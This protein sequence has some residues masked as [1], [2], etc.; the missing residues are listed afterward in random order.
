M[1]QAG[2]QVNWSTGGC[3]AD[4]SAPTSPT[5]G[6]EA[7]RRRRPRS[8]ADAAEL[9]VAAPAG[10]M[11]AWLV[12][13][14]RGG[15]AVAR[16]G[17]PGGGEQHRP[18][19]AARRAGRPR[20]NKAARSPSAD[21]TDYCRAGEMAGV[22]LATST[23]AFGA[24]RKRR[25][26]RREAVGREHAKPSQQRRGRRAAAARGWRGGAAVE[27]SAQPAGGPARHGLRA[28]PATVPAPAGERIW[29]AHPGGAH[30]SGFARHFGP[31][32]R[33]FRP[34][35]S[36]NPFP[37]PRD[38]RKC[39]RQEPPRSK[40]PQEPRPARRNRPPPTSLHRLGGSFAR[41]SRSDAPVGDS[42][43]E[44]RARRLP[45]GGFARTNRF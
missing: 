11:A 41:G 18:D 45:L 19:A 20:W 9:A 23:A 42:L 26:E 21:G 35:D 22:V 3:S 31:A 32:W 28:S 1:M 36:L 37:L 27:G 2:P 16:G 34:Q 24:A 39:G 29:R 12:T 7:Q 8:A 33:Y 14:T 15:C 30:L 13:C 6:F 43:L 38:Q 10:A 44:A 17:G 25:S 5:S 4:A 40:R